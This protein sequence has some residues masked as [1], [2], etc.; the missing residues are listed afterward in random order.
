MQML[1]RRTHDFELGRKVM[2]HRAARQSGL[3]RDQGGGGTRI[4]V[5]NEALDG[6]LDDLGPGRGA[7]L[8]LPAQGPAGSS[9]SSEGTNEVLFTRNSLFDKHVRVA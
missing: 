9:E 1:H 4:A 2:Q 8:G 6:R 5:I 3:F 7:L